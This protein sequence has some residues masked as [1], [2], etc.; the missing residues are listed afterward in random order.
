MRIPLAVSLESRD[1]GVSKDAKCVN[2]IVE[3]QGEGPT[4][5]TK[6]RTRP[7]NSDVGLVKA[8]VAQLLYSWNGINTIQADYLNRGTM[9]TIVSAPVQTNLSPANASLMWSAQETGPGAATPLLMI[10]NRTQAKSVNRAGTV[11]AITYADNMGEA[12][13]NLI[14]LTRSG[15]TATATM[16]EDVF[17]VGDTVTIAGAGQAEY[18]GAQTVTA[19]TAAV[20]TPARDIPITITRSGTTATATTVSGDH[21]LSTATYTVAGA[22]QTEYNGAKAITVTNATQFTYTVTVTP[23]TVVTWDPAH[24]NGATLS[25]GNLTAQF[26]AIG[27]AV[28]GSLGKSSGKWYWEVT[29]GALPSGL[30]VGVGDSSW[31]LTALGGDAHGWGYASF[32]GLKV[33]LVSDTYGASF[34]TADVVGVALDMDAGTL[35]FY[36]NGVSQGQAFSGITGTVYPGISSDGSTSTVNFG[37]SA[38][39]YSAPSGFSALDYDDPI[40]P[41]T[42]AIIVTD[43][44][45]TV[46]PTFSYTVAGTPA[47]PATG[48][49]TAS[50]SGGTVPGIAYINGYFCVMDVNA[51]IWNSAIDDPTS[52]SALDFVT[53]QSVNGAGKALAH[54][55]S[56]LIALKEWSTEYFYDRQD[57]A[58]GSPFSPVDNGFTEIGC[59]SGAS[60]SS[61]DGN[62]M[63]LSQSRQRGRGVYVMEGLEQRKVST[64]DV[65]RILNADDLATVHAFGVKLDGHSLYVLT[66]VSSNITLAYDLTSQTWL[67]WS[68]YTIGSVK[69]VT[70]ITRSGNTAT[71]TTSTAHTVA[72]GDPVKIV[73]ATQTEYNGI[74]QAQYVSSTIFTIQVEGDPTT[75]ATGTITAYPYTESY[76]KFTKYADYAG[77][78]LLLHESDGHLYQ[79]DST[80]YRDAG[81]P[82]NTFT[83]TTRLDGGNTDRKKMPVIRVIGDSVASL[84]MIRWSDDDCATFSAYR[85][86]DLSESRPET[87]KCGAFERRTIELRHV[88]NFPLNLTALELEIG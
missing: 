4:A 46:N 59:A 43:P 14:S 66:L 53:A 41:A 23:G 40:T 21:G 2:A 62:L 8:G 72:D 42:G 38:F 75:P 57:G 5:I 9:A 60:V 29:V 71:V 49:I 33:H 69:S 20:F 16:G 6:L 80:L 56:Y 52:W 27:V 32:S 30:T 82:I 79:L 44:A 51:V 77:L 25:G 18:N 45:V 39:A 67:P 73:G 88:G 3:V 70:S 78:N 63:W 76:F 7:G 17:G 35:T 1:G 81:L 85:L 55:G 34:T 31:A 15:A 64:P 47:T 65:E 68:S 48:T 11:A 36:K 26:S 50:S 12:T 10:K 74:F 28:R 54:S 22:N 24:N 84:A 61:I 19:I 87:R 58:T 86:I 83:R 37:A 13:Y